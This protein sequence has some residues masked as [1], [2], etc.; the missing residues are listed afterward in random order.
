MSDLTQK[1]VAIIAR[2]TPA[3]ATR[4]ESATRLSDLEIDR[5]DLPMI[6][7]DI[8]DALD[9]CIRFDERLDGVATVRDLVACTTASVE[10]KALWRR[11]RAATP[12][13]KRSWLSTEAQQR[14]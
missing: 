9:V 8:E 6:V 7:L 2:Y 1:I 3:S 4:V 12:R 13:V 11:L 14:R 5:L 10:E